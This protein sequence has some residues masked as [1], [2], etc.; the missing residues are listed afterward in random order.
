MEQQ[1]TDRS[2][3]AYYLTGAGG[4]VSA[5]GSYAEGLYKSRAAMANAD[6]AIQNAS[7][8]K[9]KAK[10]DEQQVRT[11]G[12][13]VLGDMRASY[14]ASGVTTDGSVLD[15]MSESAANVERDALF[16]RYA[17]KM[18]VKALQDEAAMNRDAAR[19]YKRSGTY[20]AV[21]NLLMTGAQMYA[22]G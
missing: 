5:Y 2:P 16:T 10:F 21:G 18:R 1:R 14:A 11:E 19:A 13:K 6:L 17:G 15:V 3:W 8:A 9:T 12:K 22:W 7:F 20:S 4:A